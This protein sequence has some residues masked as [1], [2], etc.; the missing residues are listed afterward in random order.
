MKRVLSTIGW[1]AVGL[2]LL[3]SFGLDFGN[4]S[5][6]GAIDLRN[7]ITGVRLLEHGIDPYHYKWHKGE[8]PEY[9]DPFNNPNLPVSRTTATPALL[10]LNLPLAPLPYR[11]GQVLWLVAQ[12]LLLLGTAGLC[13]R[14]CTM[15]WQRWAVALFVTGFTYT[16]AWRL[17]AERGQAYVLLAF[18]LAWWLTATLDPKRGNGFAAGFLA[19]LLAPLRPP[20]LLLAPFLALHRR[21]QLPGAAAGLLAGLA[22]PIFF[23]V[24]CWPDY[25]S[26]MRTNAELNWSHYYPHYQQA[27]PPR[28]EGVSTDVLAYYVPIPFAEFSVPALLGALGGG[29]WPDGVLMGIAGVPFAAWLWI[30]R[31][32]KAENLLAGMAAWLFLV[33]LFLPAYRNSYNDVMIL[34]VVALGV[35]GARKFPWAAWPCVLAVAAGWGVY[36]W[37]PEQVGLINLPT[38]LFAAS[39]VGFLFWGGKRGQEEKA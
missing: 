36:A 17:H 4:M 25:F 5:Q 34:D 23:Q 9:C 33:D 30:S 10:L 35:I 29:P 39:A 13:L 2:A 16:S 31:A 38:G 7:R 24:G 14:A 37:E 12:W 8:P 3:V 26:A 27:Y 28:I 18:F 11:L 1:V 22:L 21:G 19:G 6:G 15:P 32:Q 20:F